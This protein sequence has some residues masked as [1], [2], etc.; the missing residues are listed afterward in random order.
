MRSSKSATSSPVPFGLVSLPLVLVAAVSIASIAHA[1][2]P[3]FPAEWSG[4][5]EIEISYTSSGGSTP[6]LVET[7]TDSICPGDGL[8][9]EAFSPIAHCTT[10][11]VDADGVELACSGQASV[12]GCAAVGSLTLDVSRTGDMIAG[13]GSFQN[14]LSGSCP[15]PPLSE[16]IAVVGMR[17]AATPS[18]C[19]PPG[20]SFVDRFVFLPQL[21][22]LYF[23]AS[24]VGVPA[25][26]WAA[27][28]ALLGSL[29]TL[30]WRRLS[31][32]QGVRRSAR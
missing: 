18:A 19:G 11:A 20:V 9:V 22:E 12:G 15:S 31:G 2:T 17:V 27:L 25:T 29:G 24:L 14:Q 7:V 3:S 26:G 6:H 16:S 4:D 23:A 28:I 5:W 1:Q 8:G 32:M 30:G 13:G 21:D 10:H